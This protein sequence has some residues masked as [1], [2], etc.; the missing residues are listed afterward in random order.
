MAVGRRK[1]AAEVKWRVTI[2]G[3]DC[4]LEYE[5]GSGTAS[6]SLT[7]QIEKRGVASVEE[8]MPGVFSVL[9]EG[10]SYR[11]DLLSGGGE[12]AA[13]AGNQSFSIALSDQR[14]RPAKA[15]GQSAAGPMELRAQMP[16]KIVKLLVEPQSE[17]RA[18]QS[19]LV[20]EA[21][22]MQ[23]EMKSPKDGIVTA[24]YATEGATVLAG[25]RLMVVE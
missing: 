15:K 1:V 19:L 13:W 3:E 5:R 16:G 10:R 20:I 14:D 11:I 24:I 17:V 22:K 25:E 7:G 18:G 8:V 12:L 6:Y 4:L 2:D 21:M 9:L 23:N